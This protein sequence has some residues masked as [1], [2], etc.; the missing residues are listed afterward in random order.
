[1]ALA[2]EITQTTSGAAATYI[3][4][5]GCQLHVHERILRGALLGYANE[6]ACIDGKDPLIIFPEQDFTFEEIGLSES[7][8]RAALYAAMKARIDAIEARATGNAPGHPVP[9]EE[10]LNNPMRLLVGAEDV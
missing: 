8:L 5:G 10:E 9:S 4:I 3:R 1:M 6:Q 2:K 7:A